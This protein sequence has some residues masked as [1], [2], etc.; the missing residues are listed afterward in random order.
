ME[1]ISSST[2][3]VSS[4]ESSKHVEDEFNTAVEINAT[5]KVKSEKIRYSVLDSDGEPIEVV[6]N[7]KT[8]LAL[9]K[10]SFETRDTNVELDILCYKKIIR[11]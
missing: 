4:L 8:K 6:T 1:G 11:K 5:I 10:I 2:H 9:R 7:L 3:Q